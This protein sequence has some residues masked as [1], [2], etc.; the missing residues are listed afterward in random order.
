M[1][2]FEVREC[3]GP[4]GLVLNVDRDAP[5]PG[6]GQVLVRMRA[7]SL[8]YRDFSVTTGQYP[9]RQKPSVIPLSDGAGEIVALGPAVKRARLGDRVMST[10]YP[11]WVAGPITEQVTEFAL[12]GALDGVLAE[13][14]A[15]PEH[16]V[17]PVPESLTFEQ[18]STLPSAALTAWQALVV[19]AGVKAGD[20]VLVLGTGGVSLFALQLAK[21]HGA[22]VILTSSSSTKLE[23]GAQLMA[24]HLVNYREIPNWDTRVLELTAGR[25]VDIV[26][27]VGGAGTLDRSM[28]SVR[29][30]GMIVLIGRLAGLGQIDPLPLMRRAIRLVGINVGSHETFVAMNRAI[31]AGKLQPVID[32]SFPFADAKA[33]Y[34]YMHSGRQFGKVLVTI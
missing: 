9:G 8:N 12:G 24:D 3:I 10:F 34:Q 25:G 16:A 6:P 19:T 30:G 33:A 15:F 29:K 4:D 20:T 27:E 14:V 13:Y 17:I 31:E 22:T 28:R 32:R 21:L 7:A 5:E 1:K 11:D 23:R 26:I 18:A 2:A